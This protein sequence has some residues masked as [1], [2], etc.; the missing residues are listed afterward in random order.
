MTLLLVTEAKMRLLF[1]EY[2]D[3]TK[4][5]ERRT[6]YLLPSLEQLHRYLVVLWKRRCVE[7]TEKDEDQ[8]SH[9]TPQTPVEE[10]ASRRRK[11]P[12]LSDTTWEPQEF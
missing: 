7:R 9:V 2:K 1:R 12:A 4:Q 8:E 5:E 10:R 6:C 11:W 3:S